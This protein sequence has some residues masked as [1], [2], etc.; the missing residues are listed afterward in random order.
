MKIWQ[1]IVCIGSTIGVM[2]WLSTLC[3][4]KW[5]ALGVTRTGMVIDV[6]DKCCRH[7]IMSPDGRGCEYSRE[8]FAD[9][10][11]KRIRKKDEQAGSSE[12]TR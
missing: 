11:L 2:I 3:F 10:N 4:H 7:R 5:R 6:C 1:I 8:E 12:E 9:L